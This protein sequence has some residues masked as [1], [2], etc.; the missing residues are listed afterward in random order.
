MSRSER[1]RRRARRVR[2]Q[3]ILLATAVLALGAMCASFTFDEPEDVASEAVKTEKV[4]VAEVVFRE[5]E[6]EYQIVHLPV[7]TGEPLDAEPMATETAEAVPAEEPEP[8]FEEIPLDRETQSCILNWCE[9]YGV[10]HS[11]ALGVIQSESSF[12]PDAENGSCYGYMQINSINREWLGDA[13]GLR[14]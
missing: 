5:D 8:F 6:D 2:R 3:R 13:I 11:I 12:Q 4:A 7:E 1:R 14:I 10:P 9:E